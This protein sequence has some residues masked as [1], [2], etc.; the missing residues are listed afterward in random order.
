MSR[1]SRFRNVAQSPHRLIELPASNFVVGVRHSDMENSLET[2]TF[3]ETMTFDED[4]DFNSFF[5]ELSDAISN[6][7]VLSYGFAISSKTYEARHF[8]LNKLLY[9]NDNPSR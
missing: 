8:K 1:N 6:N 5:L 7:I 2:L 4:I 3:N 9:I